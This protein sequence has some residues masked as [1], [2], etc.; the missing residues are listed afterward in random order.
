ME[1]RKRKKP[2][3]NVLEAR[4]RLAPIE[5]QKENKKRKRKEKA[6]L[7]NELPHKRGIVAT[8]FAVVV[9]VVN[10][11]SAFVLRDSFLAM[12]MTLVGIVLIIGGG[13]FATHFLT[14]AVTAIDTPQY[15]VDVEHMKRLT[16]SLKKLGAI[17]ENSAVTLEEIREYWYDKCRLNSLVGKGYVGRTDDGRLYL[18]KEMET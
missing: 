2:T 5:G 6:V 14:G 1:K 15:L 4:H 7:G 13:V 3:L 17:D 18:I 12:S 9:G 10:V 16:A 11:C 8:G